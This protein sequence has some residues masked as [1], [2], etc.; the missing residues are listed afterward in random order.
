MQDRPEHGM[1][2]RSYTEAV[3]QG[4]QKAK[5]GKAMHLDNTF[6]KNLLAACPAASPASI[7][8]PNSTSTLSACWLLA[9]HKPAVNMRQHANAPRVQEA[10]SQWCD[11]C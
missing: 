2:K 4:V 9:L 3:L 11:S 8:L 6:R 5:A 1:T 10:A 7:I